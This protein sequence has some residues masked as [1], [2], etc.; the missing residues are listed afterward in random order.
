MARLEIEQA[1][2]NPEWDAWVASAPGGHHVQTSG[3]AQVKAL[4]GWRAT[5]LLVRSD[6]E[7]VGGCQM[8][9]RDLP[10]SRR[11]G[12]VPRGPLLAS[13]EPEALD[14]LLA[15]MRSVARDQR[16][17][18]MKVQPP[19][20]RDDMPGLLRDRGFA[21]S[22]LH[23]APGAS[24]R[25]ELS[26][27]HDD[28]A[29]QKA[30][31]STARRH[32]RTAL[33]RGAVVRVGGKDDLGVLQSLLEATAARQGFD[34]YPA[35]YYERLWDAFGTTGQARLLIVEHEGTPMSA[36][37]LIAFGDTVLYKIGAWGGGSVPG[38]NELMHHTAM[39]WARDQ[40]Y[41]FYDFEG[42]PVDVAQTVLDG[43]PAPTSG[44]PFFKLG[45][46]G[47]PIVFPGA[48]DLFFGRLLGPAAR[49][50]VPRAERSRT[51]VHRL[52]GR[53]A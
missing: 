36:G 16:L 34:P 43:G 2:R 17:L 11:A 6:G 20:D 39:C 46:G 41:R 10:L 50:L 25:V 47:E 15:G 13:R 52:A 38:T 3:W 40:G 14:E 27:D 5:R 53:G 35:A 26:P 29:L 32:L 24:V 8:L 9:V 31:R 23:A 48:H 1:E 42:I 45:F 18:M 49:R 19:V 21:P 28:A 12:Y 51:M 7:I 33:K 37:L 44:V 22:E 30:M 4:A